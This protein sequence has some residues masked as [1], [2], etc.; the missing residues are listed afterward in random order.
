MFCN[1]CGKE[2]PNGVKFCPTCGAPVPQTNETAGSQ[3]TAATGTGAMAGS[4]MGTETVTNPKLGIFDASRNHQNGAVDFV[5]C[6]GRHAIFEFRDFLVDR[7]VCGIRICFHVRHV[8]K[9][10]RVCL[11]A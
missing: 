2:I 9:S 11:V 4:G 6:G 10:E 7:F 8:S 5:L 3:Q 1:Q